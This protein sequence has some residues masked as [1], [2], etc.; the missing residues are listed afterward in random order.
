M[1]YNFKGNKFLEI[2]GSVIKKGQVF[3]EGD[4]GIWTD[5]KLKRIFPNIHEKAAGKRR[6][7]KLMQDLAMH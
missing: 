4:R 5:L 7:T 6:Y 3:L 1:S 2:L